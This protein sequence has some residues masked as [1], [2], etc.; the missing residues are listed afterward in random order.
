VLNRLVPAASVQLAP[1]LADYARNPGSVPQIRQ[2]LTSYPELETPLLAKLSWDPSNADLIMT[3]A[4]GKRAIGPAP[5][6]QRLML[7]TLVNN[8][9]YEK[10]Y[11]LWRKLA[12]V[13][14]LRSGFYDPGFTDAS[15]P[16]PFNWQLAQ[17]AGGVAERSSGNL[18]V[19]YFGRDDAELA[20][21]VLLLPPGRYRLTMNVSGD[22]A[23]T[24]GISWTVTCLRS[25]REAL[26][27]RL[28]KAGS[29]SSE[30]VVPG[31][32]CPAQ[33]VTLGAVAPEIP[34]GADFRISGLQLTSLRQ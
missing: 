19:L 9:Q 28:V 6:W 7:T 22:V 4:S 21:Q 27:M 13:Q 3:L 2:I 8:G 26:K 18:Q 11:T 17:G 30:F 15:A 20:S 24:N 14:G 31:S 32:D 5:D 10:A 34:D 12:D 1:S 29:V 25:Q 16:A 33:R 23:D